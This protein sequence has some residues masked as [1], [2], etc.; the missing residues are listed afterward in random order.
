[1]SLFS[2]M[3]LSFLSYCMHAI[4]SWSSL[5]RYCC[6]YYYYYYYF[7]PYA[8]GQ[9]VLRGYQGI[10]RLSQDREGMI[11]TPRSELAI[12]RMWGLRSSHPAGHQ[13]GLRVVAWI[14]WSPEP[15]LRGGD[16]QGEEGDTDSSSESISPLILCPSPPMPPSS[17]PNRTVPWFS[18]GKL[19]FFRIIWDCW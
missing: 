15:E 1:M 7:A 17:T 14:V 12:S 6:C 4:E 3:F 13:L 5:G 18:V 8:D 9:T 19:G 2:K 11:S 10:W 16:M